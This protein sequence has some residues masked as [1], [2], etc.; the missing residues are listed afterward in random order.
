MRTRRELRNAVYEKAYEI[1]GNKYYKGDIDVVLDAL[2]YVIEERLV[3]DESVHIRGFGTFNVHHYH[4]RRVINPRTKEETFVEAYNGVK[5][6]PGD[7][8]KRS[9]LNGVVRYEAVPDDA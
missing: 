2:I 4:K 1:S 8:L 7:T 6:V 3:N 5:F 9:M